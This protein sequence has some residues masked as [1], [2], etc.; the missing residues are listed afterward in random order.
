MRARWFVVAMV[1]GS[2]PV[3]AAPAQPAIEIARVEVSPAQA[4]LQVGQTLQMAAKVLDSKGTPVPNARVIWFGGGDGSVDSTG[5]VR[6]GFRGYV[7]VVAM[8]IAPGSKRVTEQVRVRV[9]PAPAARLQLSTTA[10]KLAVGSHYSLS[11]VPMSAESDIRYDAVTFASDKPT[12]VTITPDGRLQAVRPGTAIVTGTA[13]AAKATVAVEVVAVTP[14]SLVVTPATTSTRTG[15]VVRFSATAKDRAGNPIEGLTPRWS[16]SAGG[17]LGIAQID[18]DGA[19][20]A[21]EQGSYTVSASIGNLTADATVI[22]SPRHVA[23]GIEVVGRVPIPERGGEVWPH[24]GGQ[25][26]Y[27]STISDRVYAIDVTD[28]AKPRIVDSMKIDARIINDV[29]TTEDGKYGVFSRE[30][31]SNRKN[32]IA[33]FDASDPC[34]PK[35]ISD[36]NATV[37]G[38]VHSSYVYQGHVYLTDDATGSMRVISIKDPYNPREV[39]RWQTSQ[40]EAGRYVH[41]IDVRGGL[42][43]LSYWNDGLIILDIGNGIRGGSPEKPVQVSQLKYD[44]NHL[45]RRID[46][47]YGL[48]ARGTHTSWRHKNY[49]F[50]ADE[51]YAAKAAK[52]HQNG[53]DLTWGRLQV[54]D[55]SDITKPKIVAWYEPTD[56]GVH[57]VWAEGDSLYIG[58]YQGGGRVLDISGELKGDLLRQ[59][60][61]IA[62]LFTADS[63]GSR[64]RATFTWGAAVKDGLIYFNDINTGLWITR[65]EKKERPVP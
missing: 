63:A 7:N 30:G 52:G 21:E 9:T 40:S 16:V 26:V 24:P 4:E 6:G 33:I 5:L 13:G 38:G 64:P 50:I 32:G 34:H 41:D 1:G 62:W 51:V 57:N 3:V 23:R 44:L 8:A 19:F 61:E 10:L 56:G 48:G 60:R 14:A 58:S 15:D 37:T 36:Y 17:Q 11:G 55:V 59:G 47:M 35:V 22:A 25:C 54:V 46:D 29:M 65:L 20:V 31:A 45:Y 12:I 2:A 39:G 49:I 42:A 28:P 43:Y 27:Y 18:G 53:N